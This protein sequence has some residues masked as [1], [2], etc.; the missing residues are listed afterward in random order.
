[1]KMKD[2]VRAHLLLPLLSLVLCLMASHAHAQSVPVT[3]KVTDA[4]LEQVLNAIEKQTPYLFVYDKNVDVARKVSVDAADRPLSDVLVTLAKTA[5]ISYAVENTSIVLS[6]KKA[7]QTGQPA[8]VTGRI[9]DNAGQPIIGAAVLVKGSTIGTST[10]AD[11]SYTL[12][13]PPP[14]I[15]PY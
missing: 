12:Q 13:V 10:G 11:G 5:N 15:R 6:Q 2:L 3:L 14:Q 1:M 9:L 4:P 8:T 7:V